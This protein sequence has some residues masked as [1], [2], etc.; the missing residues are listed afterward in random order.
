MPAVGVGSVLARSDYTDL[1]RESAGR[2]GRTT[3]GHATGR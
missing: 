2:T 1:I 3:D